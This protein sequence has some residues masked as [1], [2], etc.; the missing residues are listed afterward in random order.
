MINVNLT[1][2]ENFKD[3]LRIRRTCGE[4]IIGL[5][6]YQDFCPLTE[7]ERKKSQEQIFKEEKVINAVCIRLAHGDEKMGTHYYLSYMKWLDKK[8]DAIYKFM[9]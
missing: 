3:L 6:S 7:G 9:D 2:N 4:H 1:N 5:W 8:M